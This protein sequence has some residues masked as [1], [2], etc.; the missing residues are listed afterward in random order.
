ML[1][2]VHGAT[3]HAP[4]HILKQ[5]YQRLL[6]ALLF[7]LLIIQVKQEPYRHTG[8]CLGCRFIQ[9]DNKHAIFLIHIVTFSLNVFRNFVIAE[10]SLDTDNP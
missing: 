10:K 7:Y 4:K 8:W 2:S 1:T 3:D 5:G 6:V 9:I